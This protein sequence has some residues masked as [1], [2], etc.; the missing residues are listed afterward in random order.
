VTRLPP[1]LYFLHELKRRGVAD[2]WLVGGV[3]RDLLLERD[4]MDVDIVCGEA[5][6]ETLV[7]KVGG[8]VVGRP[9]FYTVST[10]LP[11]PPPGGCPEPSGV[12]PSDRHDEAERAEPERMQKFDS[13]SMEITLLT[14]GSIQKDLGR[15]DFTIN[16][17]AMDI[18]GQIIDPFG[19]AR[20]IRRRV[21]RV[22]PAPG[23]SPCEVYEA[24]PVRVVRLLR[25]AC[26]LGFEIDFET[27]AL[28]KKFIR[29]HRPALENIPGERYGK[30]FL[31][32]FA[33]RPCD[34]LTLLENYGLL[35]TLL[36][37]IEAMRGVEQP[38]AFHPE[39][40]VLAHTFRVAAE[41]QK[42]IGTRPDKQ[43]IVLALAALLHDVGKPGSVRA[44]P[45]YERVCFFGHEQAGE[46]MAADMLT[47]WAVPGKIAEQVASLVR[48]HMLP[49]GDFTERTCVKLL[50]QMGADAERLFDLA[51]CDVRGA[52]GTGENILSARKLFRK[53][54]DNLASGP[55][56]RWLD[57][58]DVMDILQ[59]PPGRQVGRILEEL[60]V[61][62]GAGKLRTRDEA[63]EWLRHMYP[64]KPHTPDF[65]G[66]GE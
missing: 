45:K 56:R 23:A 6:A 65:A 11:G 60:D 62:I 8:A 16:A 30:E 43:D 21:L 55:A 9:P 13:P 66:A 27:E 51:L 24:D 50:R 31:K 61:A 41:A 15:R 19:G 29:E 32:G 1:F 57:G 7:A 33:S 39:G 53:V 3:V 44:H 2:A 40:D 4:P 47:A 42:A 20:D 63:V 18:D 35:P 52:M 59:I 5:D 12:A 37:E 36:P 58:N 22:V 34:F 14:G 54:R 48:R 25:F 28:T 38:A 46:Q 49:G 17:L 10:S 26:T 64:F